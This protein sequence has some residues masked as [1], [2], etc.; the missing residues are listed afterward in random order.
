[1]YRINSSKDLAKVI[2]YTNL[3]NIATE[4]EIIEFLEKAKKCNFHSVVISPCY[5]P[6]A[7]N[8]LKDTNIRIG[9]V[10]SFPLGFETTESKLAQTAIALTNGA[11]EIDMVVNLSL[12][13]S[14]K[15][16]EIEDEVRKVKNLVGDKV[17]K[18]IIETKALEDDEKAKVS[19][20]IERAG[21]D[22]IKTATGFVTPNNIYENVNDINIIQKYAPK[23]KI[24]VSGG[25]NNYKIANQLIT[26]GAD[27]IGTSVGYEIIEDFKDLKENAKITPKPIQFD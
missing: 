21:A 23:T 20:A 1:M 26:A 17:L 13:K 3:S 4:E 12:V 10:I 25:I 8:Y 24:K 18:V 14:K 22:F 16:K 2:E 6:L 7:K 11:D 19:I 5:V 9:T 15:Y 27:K